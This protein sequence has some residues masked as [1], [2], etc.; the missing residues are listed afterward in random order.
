METL[1]GSSARVELGSGYT[2][3]APGVR[4]TVDASRR[5]PADTRGGGVEQSEPVLEAALEQQGMSEIRVIE[6]NVTESSVPPESVSSTRTSSGAPGM[7]LEVPDLGPD[8][9][10]VVMVIDDGVV[11]WSYSTDSPAVAATRGGATRS[12]IIRQPVVT[13]ATHDES[14]TRGLI[15]AIGKRVLRV[16]VY[17]IADLVLGPVTE[18][19]AGL[20][21]KKYR[22]YGIRTFTPAN[23]AEKVSEP[24]DASQWARL[25]EGRS[26][27]FVHGT[28]SSTHS[29]FNQLDVAT[30]EALNERYEGRVF[31]FDHP[32]V[33]VS[34]DKNAEYFAKQLASHLPGKTVDV[35]IVCHSRGGLVSR[36]L[37]GEFGAGDMSQLSVHKTVF[38]AVPNQGTI[39][40][41]PDYM[42][43]FIDRYTSA[44]DFAPPGPVQVV[45][46]ILESLLMV[47]KIIGHAGLVSLD[48]LVAQNP[49]GNLMSE[50]SATSPSVEGR[51]AVAANYEPKGNFALYVGDGVVDK[52]FEDAPNDLVVPTLGVDQ[53]GQSRVDPNRVL[54]I[55]ASRSVWHGSFF[56]QPD[57]QEA[58]LRWLA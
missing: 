13:A 4:G 24:M 9:E 2:L 17:P 27:L 30:V 1:D 35:D 47:V 18:L 49:Q 16:L 40:A 58:L 44:L 55:D 14:E 50:L 51:Y 54:S 29:A 42:V 34:P 56:K 19:F 52:V 43:S 10:I 8:H 45:S 46:D 3:T 41:N 12:F 31:A 23:Y 22:P 7:V 25:S 48:G 6:L 26:L 28:F 39:L 20:W 21:E 37:A 5:Q 11:T 57:V 32:S 33:S 36:A 38:V 53:L 15:A